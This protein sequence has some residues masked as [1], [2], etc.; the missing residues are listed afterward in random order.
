MK[1]A[2][3]RTSF[4]ITVILLLTALFPVSAFAADKIA[5]DQPGSLAI[6][7]KWLDEA[8]HDAEFRIYKV[9]VLDEYAHMT[10]T[11]TFYPYRSSVNGLNSL[12]N[13]ES[14]SEWAELAETLKSIVQ[15][16][17]MIPFVIGKTDKDGHLLFSD[18][19]PGLYLVVGSRTSV[20]NYIYTVNPFFAFLPGYDY[21]NDAWTYDYDIQ[22]EMKSSRRQI[23]SE[24]DTITRKVLKIWD[25]KGH[26]ESRPKEIIVQLLRDNQIYDTVIL[27]EKNNWRYSWTDLDPKYEW[28]VVEKEI[29]ADYTAIMTQIGITFV[30]TNTRP[31]YPPPPDNPPPDNPPPD[32]P[33]QN[34]SSLISLPRITL[35]R[36]T[37][38]D[39][40]PADTLY[41]LPQTGMLWWPVPLLLCAGFLFII[42][43]VIRSRKAES[44]KT[45]NESRNVTDNEQ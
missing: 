29:P 40:S 44:R 14:Q 39:T 9:A 26:E 21:E 30:I 34:T 31:E 36:I 10:L 7:F 16:D 24:N 17:Q 15:R 32:N 38:T 18:L 19:R 42:T 27:N 6:H 13:I 1:T 12:D 25:D 20:G 2:H 23:P 35:P 22:V 33:P 43:G 45:K 41:L 5:A 8:I 37:P 4:V 28:L 11:D 3:K